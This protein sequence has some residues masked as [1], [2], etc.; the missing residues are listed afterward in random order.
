MYTTNRSLL[1]FLIPAFV[2]QIVIMVASLGVSLPQVRD[3][4]QCAEV[5]FPVG[6]IAYRRACFPCL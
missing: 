1:Y 6:I 3:S 4:P 5:F 2:V